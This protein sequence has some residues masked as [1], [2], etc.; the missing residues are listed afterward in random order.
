MHRHGIAWFVGRRLAALAVVLVVI[1]L[2][3]FSL[4]YLAPGSPEQML[5]GP[6]EATP[7]SVAAIRH[8]YHLDQPFLVQY[9]DWA[10]KAAQLD[11]GRS[12]L[13]SE[14][15]MRAIEPR[16]W[17]SLELAGFAFLIALL[18]GVSLG[19]VASLRRRTTVDRT[20]VGLSV[21]G[22][23]A[24]AFATGVLL[25]YLFA[26]RLGWFPVFGQGS[27]VTDRLQHLTLPAVALGL[28]AMG[29][30]LRLTRAGAISALEQDYVAFARARGIRRRRILTAYVMRNSLVPIVTGAGLI[31]AYLLAGAVLVEVTFALPGIGSLLVD[32]ITA[33]DIPV[34]QALAM[35]IAFVVVLINLAVDLL[36]LAIDPRIRHGAIGE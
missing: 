31:L 24:P 26:V 20:I 25:L 35:L 8:V 19:I 11:F 2:V 18:L 9:W 12:I 30:I 14:P 6:R 7:A 29:L 36:Y 5:L 27:G 33:K 16:L 17:L 23:S 1:S 28:T 34:V 21:V 3:V 13:T 10:S 4:L 22:V 32:S 15:V